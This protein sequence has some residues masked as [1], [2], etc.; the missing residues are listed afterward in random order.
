MPVIINGIKGANTLT[1]LDCMAHRYEL[2]HPIDKVRIIDKYS[3]LDSRD[4]T[5]G[6]GDNGIEGIEEF[7][8]QHRCN[9][10]CQNMGLASVETLLFKLKGSPEVEDGMSLPSFLYQYRI[11]H[12]DTEIGSS[13]GSSIIIPPSK[14]IEDPAQ[15]T[16]AE[17]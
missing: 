4:Q 11:S 2:I 5:M 16:D 7:C 13:L 15:E 6:L 14:L 10:I 9:S 3:F 1:L 12:V 8:K 17:V